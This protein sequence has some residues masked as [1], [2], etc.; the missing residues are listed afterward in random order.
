MSEHDDVIW[1]QD[2]V[3]TDLD[4][5][6]AHL[7]EVQPNVEAARQRIRRLARLFDRVLAEAAERHKLSVGDWEALSVLQRAGEPHELLPGQLAAALGVTSGTMSLRIDRLTRAGLVEPASGRRV[8][9]RRRPVRL[10]TQGRDR[11]RAATNERTRHEHDLLATSL[12]ARDL[13]RLNSLLG[14]LLSRFEGELGPAPTH[15]PV[16]ANPPTD[17]G[18]T[19][20]S[21]PRSRRRS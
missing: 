1:P 21:A 18:A 3:A 11:W 17:G 12:E 16:G 4:T 6:M 2:S 13:D 8:D 20:L 10:T 9:G 19:A 7:P 14:A 5:W 15:G